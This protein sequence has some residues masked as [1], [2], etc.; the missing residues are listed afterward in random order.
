M[1]KRETDARYRVLDVFG[2]TRVKEFTTEALQR[3][4]MK[5]LTHNILPQ[6]FQLTKDQGAM[7]LSFTETPSPD[8]GRVIVVHKDVVVS[9]G[10][11]SYVI[12]I[13]DGCTN[14]TVLQIAD[15]EPQKGIQRSLSFEDNLLKKSL[16]CENGNPAIR[17]PRGDNLTTKEQIEFLKKVSEAK[18]NIEATKKLGIKI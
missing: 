2:L 15:Y 7:R 3:R 13:N 6:L 18:V 12:S 11:K 1:E 8:N 10:N 9:Q 4:Q 16:K 17:Y 5:R 14:S